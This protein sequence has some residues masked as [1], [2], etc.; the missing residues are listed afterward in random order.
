MELKLNRKL[1]LEKY[2]IVGEI[3]FKET[4]EEIISYL[5]VAKQYNNYMS[6]ENIGRDLL[7]DNNPAIG[8][9]IIN[10]CQYLGLINEDQYLTTTG[11]EAIDNKAVLIPEEG[12]Y[13]IIITTDPLY[14]ET[15][16]DL[17]RSENK[18]FYAELKEIKN[19]YNEKKKESNDSK[20]K[21]LNLKKEVPFYVKRL[22]GKII[23]LQDKQI[24]IYNIQP[25]CQ[26]IR[27]SNKEEL[28]LTLSL[29]EYKDYE[30]IFSGLIKNTKILNLNKNFN[31]LFKELLNSEAKN[32]IVRNN[33]YKFHVKYENLSEKE[34]NTF[35]KDLWLKEPSL[36]N[37]GS[38]RSTNI[39]NIPITPQTDQD[40]QKWVEFLVW[41]DITDYITEEKY[42][43]IWQKHIQL[44]TGFYI[45]RISNEDL[46]KSRL[47]DGN[48]KPNQFWYIQIP[49]LLSEERL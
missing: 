29:S 7:N 41:N 49:N 32:W 10:L 47:K 43:S 3:G 48:N 38:F 14:P 24:K 6:A 12:V 8:K 26:E 25:Y 27:P 17:K 16:I 15:L 18:D 19:Q 33:Q 20:I 36:E 42:I 28:F 2:Y 21:S 34:L 30:L 11:L 37:Y 40:A 9:R 23:N 31:N 45:Y 39:E 44:F 35:Y 46:F 1:N 13:E 5:L 22:V 4:R